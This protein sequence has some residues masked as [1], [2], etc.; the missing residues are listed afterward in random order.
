MSLCGLIWDV[1]IAMF[2]ESVVASFME[3]GQWGRVLNLYNIRQPL[4]LYT[5][6]CLGRCRDPFAF[7]LRKG[8]LSDEV[9]IVELDGLGVNCNRVHCFCPCDCG[10]GGGVP[11]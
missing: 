7:E 10:A 4:T 6:G 2:P 9:V 1:P 8:S 11:E 3:F 5:W